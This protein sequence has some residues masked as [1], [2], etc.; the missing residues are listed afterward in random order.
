[1]L[2]DL[3]TIAAFILGSYFLL[4]VSDLLLGGSWRAFL[5][6]SW[7]SW[8]YGAELVVG[9]LLPVAIIALP[10]MRK[11][12]VALGLAAALASGGLVLNRLNVGIF[13][14]L[15]SA[16]AFY[17]PSLAEWAL[18][19]GVIAAA[20]LAFLAIS[21]SCPIFDDQWEK[22][23]VSKGLFSASFDS[24]S[25]VWITVLDDGL[26]RVTLIA[27]MVVPL[28]WMA[29]YPPF[30]NAGT[31]AAPVSPSTAVDAERR[32]L[33]IDG[34]REYLHTLFPHA[35]HQDRLRA[36]P[37]CVACHHVSLPGDH[38]T[39]C[40]RCHVDMLK[41]SSIFDHLAHMES[42]AEAQGV[43][44]LHPENRSCEICHAPG[45]AESA[46]SAKSCLECHQEDIWMSGVPGS[47]ADL[48]RAPGFMEAMHGTCIPCHQREDGAR[49][50]SGLG[51]CSTCHPSLAKA[52]SACVGR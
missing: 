45:Q 6:G 15:R 38:N 3:A 17:F 44:G 2:Q 8:L 29:M 46:R 39:P 24:L 18:G 51:E 19:L 26:Q 36:G 7:E 34:D 52:E 5:A 16:E 10:A 27:V 43:S 42:V 49:H 23:R 20:G 32:V 37:G 48:S 14:Y 21:E 30:T 22:R 28:A 9:V 11:S 41:P 47:G 1:M 25:H 35:E 40:S 33:R 13:G 4:K 31:G 12:P 50:R